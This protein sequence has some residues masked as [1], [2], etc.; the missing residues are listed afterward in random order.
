MP[1]TASLRPVP[2]SLAS[3][4]APSAVYEPFTRNF[5]TRPPPVKLHAPSMSFWRVE[6]GNVPARPMLARA[7]TI[8]RAYLGAGCAACGE[9][10]LPGSRVPDTLDHHAV[11]QGD[12]ERD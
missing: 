11:R 12:G 2:P 6:P 10:E 3:P 1:R 5:G 8:G 9:T 7:D 4:R